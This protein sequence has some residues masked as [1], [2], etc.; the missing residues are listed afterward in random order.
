MN[1][2]TFN[3]FK[4]RQPIYYRPLTSDETIIKAVIVDQTEYMFPRFDPKIIFDIGA[5]IGVVSVVL[6]N[7]YPDA[8]IYSF[9]PEPKN[10][11]LLMKNTATYKNILAVERALWSDTREI[12]LSPSEDL[13]NKGGFGIDNPTTIPVTFQALGSRAACEAYGEPELIKIDCE[14]SEYRILASMPLASVKWI[15]GELHSHR[16]FLLLDYLQP[17]FYLKTDPHGFRDK[18]WHF[19]AHS[20]AWKNSGLIKD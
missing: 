19:H 8:K 14:G 18:V 1:L 16:D 2:E 12:D 4:D 13:S 17:K 3:A 10:Y 7:I 6:A 15:A 9:E 11:E 5:N 20:K